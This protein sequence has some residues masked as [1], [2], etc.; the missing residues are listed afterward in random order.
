[1][2]D[3]QKDLPVFDD[4][5]FPG[6]D[7]IANVYKTNMN[8]LYS[9]GVVQVQKQALK[10]LDARI[11]GVASA[12]EVKKSFIPKL[13]NAKQKLNQ[14]KFKDTK[15]KT[16][17]CINQGDQQTYIKLNILKQATYLTCEYDVY[18]QYAKDYY[19]QPKNVLESKED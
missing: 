10:N 16:V 14:I 18:M 5:G 2:E 8:N 1:M 7:A 19:A 3:Y 15:G 4:A 12:P 9:C 13:Q 6:I 11:K 17:K